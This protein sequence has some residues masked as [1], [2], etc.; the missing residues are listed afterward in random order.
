MRAVTINF[1]ETPISRFL[2]WC[3]SLWKRLKKIRLEKKL[4]FRIF[5]LFF[6]F[7]ILAYEGNSFQKLF[8]CLQGRIPMLRG[9]R[10]TQGP[11]PLAPPCHF[12]SSY[13]RNVILFVQHLF[14]KKQTCKHLSLPTSIF[15]NFFQQKFLGFFFLGGP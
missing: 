7:E 13:F 9:P 4:F 11:G 2:R 10:L 6:F 12:R 1:V 5:Y 3:F 15:Q 8:F 14:M